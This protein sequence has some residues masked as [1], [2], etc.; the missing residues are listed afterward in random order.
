MQL[1]AAVRS[2]CRIRHR[3]WPPFHYAELRRTRNGAYEI[4]RIAPDGR[5]QPVD[6]RPDLQA[7]QDWK[8]LDLRHD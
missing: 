5:I 7:G 4:C 2:G 6:L 8:I 3:D 1:V